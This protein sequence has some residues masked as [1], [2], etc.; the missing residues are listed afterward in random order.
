MWGAKVSGRRED[1]EDTTAFDGM[2]AQRKLGFLES[3]ALSSNEAP[4]VS[5]S[6]SAYAEAFGLD[7]SRL[8]E[9]I[10]SEFTPAC[11]LAHIDLAGT[12]PVD[13]A[14]TNPDASADYDG[15]PAG[16]I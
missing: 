13:L 16:N 12:N 6:A 9:D 14:G 2:L 7:L 10:Q 15:N 1:T 11:A 3:R 4:G 8:L 5:A